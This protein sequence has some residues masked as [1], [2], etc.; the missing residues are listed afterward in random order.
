[1]SDEVRG[2]EIILCVFVGLVVTSCFPE[3][4]GSNSNCGYRIDRDNDGVAEESAVDEYDE[5]GHLVERRTMSDQVFEGF[6]GCTVRHYSND[7][8]GK[9]LTEAVD[10]NCDGATEFT[11]RRTWNVDGRPTSYLA[12]DRHISWTYEDGLLVSK[13]DD[14]NGYVTLMRFVY[15]EESRRLT[16]REEDRGDDGSLDEVRHYFY[17]EAGHLR[18]VEVDKAA[19]GSVDEVATCVWEPAEQTRVCEEFTTSQRVVTAYNLEDEPVWSEIYDKS[20]N[21]LRSRTEWRYDAEGRRVRIEGDG[22][23]DGVVDSV[24]VWSYGCLE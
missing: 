16:R 23:G 19:D 7:A 20:T 4:T 9:P 24:S 8:R 3:S 1:V 2:R 15:D 5:R 11:V 6:N 17:D 12:D 22:D 13:R 14:S 18:R 21:E 10:I